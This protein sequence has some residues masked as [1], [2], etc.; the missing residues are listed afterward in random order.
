[1]RKVGISCC[2]LGQT[3]RYDGGHKLD[4]YLTE[5]LGE[6]VQ[7]VALCPEVG[8]GLSVPRE[9]MRLV[10]DPQAPRMVTVR[11]GV[12]H[13]ARMQRWI[14]DALESLAQEP[15][16]GYIFKSKSPSCGMQGV[17]VYTDGGMPSRRGVG[18]FARAFM[19]RF[20]LLPVEEEGRLH[21]GELRENFLVRIF[22]FERWRALRAQEV[23]ARALF[24][25][26]AEHKYLLMAH[27]PTHLRQ[28]GALIAGA[29]QRVSAQLLDAYLALMMDGLKRIATVKKNC[30]VLQHMMG[31]FKKQ[32]SA[33]EKQELLD[34]MGQY[35]RELVPLVVPQTLIRHYVRK[36]EAAYLARQ[37]YLHPHPAE[38]MLRNRV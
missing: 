6:V 33:D 5:V 22:T 13:N 12:E 27:S 14:D 20:P 24:D 15:L 4:R 38:L 23:S 35:A 31:Y 16:C 18:L 21:D 19:E 7:W 29:G 34:V 3:V 36:Y 26:H 8:C 37:Y 11:S 17:K 25:F 9:A 1:M 28:L 32:L 10:G 30:N 2:L